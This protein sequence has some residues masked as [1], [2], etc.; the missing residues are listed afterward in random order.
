LN[1][2]LAVG[3]ALVCA[4]CGGFCAE[5]LLTRNKPKPDVDE[6]IKERG[7]FIPKRNCK[8]EFCK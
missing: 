1:I 2:Y 8:G 3:G 6:L 4:F 5:W 7:G